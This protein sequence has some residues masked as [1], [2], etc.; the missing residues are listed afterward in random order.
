MILPTIRDPRFITIRRGGTLTDADHR[1]L[2]LWAADAVA[3]I[4]GIVMDAAPQLSLFAFHMEGPGL[5]TLEAQNRAT[6]DLM[7][8]VTRR[9]KVMVTGAQVGERFLGR[10]CVLSFRTRRAEME[11]AV[12]HLREAAAAILAG[13]RA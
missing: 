7:E 13:A 5:G 1:L 6:R 4:P 12:A 11:T 8:Q 3:R 10:V 2:A 9:G